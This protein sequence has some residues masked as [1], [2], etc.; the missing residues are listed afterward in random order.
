M[1][2]LLCIYALE[3]C[4]F[5]H[6]YHH[7]KKKKWTRNFNN[8]AAETLTYDSTILTLQSGGRAVCGRSRAAPGRGSSNSTRGGGFN[9]AAEGPAGAGAGA[10]LWW[11]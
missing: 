11:R 1:T 8:E 7:L 3:L 10:A 5:H 4:M 2:Q 6:V 9:R